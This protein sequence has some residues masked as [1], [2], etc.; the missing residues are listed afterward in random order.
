MNNFKESQRFPLSSHSFRYFHPTGADPSARFVILND[1][2]AE[3]HSH[4]V[5]GHALGLAIEEDDLLLGEVN[6]DKAIPSELIALNVALNPDQAFTVQPVGPSARYGGA[7]IE[8]I[9]DASLRIHRNTHFYYLDVHPINISFD[10]VT[11]LF[12]TE[13]RDRSTHDGSEPIWYKVEKT[14]L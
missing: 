5:T 3:I 9:R 8:D 2:G 6:F 4:D 12:Q 13:I 1:Q 10:P 7:G 14:L 11:N